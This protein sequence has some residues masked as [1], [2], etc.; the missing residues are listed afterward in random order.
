MHTLDRLGRN[1]RKVL[2]LV[3]DLAEKH[4]GVHSLADPLP[5]NTADDGMGPH[6]LPTAGPVRRDGIYL[7]RRA[8]GCRRLRRVKRGPRPRTRRGRR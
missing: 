6:R 2:N 5:I 3:H 7:H 4:I 8:P 1:L